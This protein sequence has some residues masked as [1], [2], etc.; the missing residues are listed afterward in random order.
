MVEETEY[1]KS[2]KFFYS[3]L[4]SE[5]GFS[6]VNDTVN[7]NAF[8]E[9]EYRDEEKAISISY[10]NIEDYLEVIV[11]KLLNGEMP[12]YDDKSQ[13]LHINQL[14]KLI[15]SR[16]SQTEIDSNAE[17]FSR[18]IPKGELERKLLKGAIELRLCLRHFDQLDLV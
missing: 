16:V 5:F 11:F 1:L 4:K 14:N 7:G 12:N 15:M 17:Y 2:V 13:T 10:E 3:F 8:Y 9:V 18:F 6:K